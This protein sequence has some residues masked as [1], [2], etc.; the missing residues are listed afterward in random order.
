MLISSDGD[1]GFQGVFELQI[2][3]GLWVSFKACTRQVFGSSKP[4]SASFQ[5]IREPGG[6]L[7][8]TLKDKVPLDNLA[9]LAEKGRSD[10]LVCVSSMDAE[11]SLRNDE[12]SSSD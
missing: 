11:E 3:E 4:D 7:W 5:T 6:R 2:G 8:K 12:S 10:E 9:W 1:S